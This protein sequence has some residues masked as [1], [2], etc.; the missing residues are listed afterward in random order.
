MAVASDLA[1]LVVQKLLVEPYK[2]S[3][4]TLGETGVWIFILAQGG[5]HLEIQAF[6]WN[7]YC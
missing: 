3:A 1:R 4:E 5:E 6:S 7:S 2:S